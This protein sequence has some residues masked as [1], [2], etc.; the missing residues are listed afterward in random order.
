MENL[1]KG[2]TKTYNKSFC[3]NRGLYHLEQSSADMA[4]L[5]RFAF[6]GIKWN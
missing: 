2:F 1:K 6:Y 3:F 4:L 5:I